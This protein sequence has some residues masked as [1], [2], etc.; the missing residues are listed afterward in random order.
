MNLAAATTR[1]PWWS[2]PYWN[3]RN[4]FGLHEGWRNWTCTHW[5]DTIRDNNPMGD[6]SC[7]FVNNPNGPMLYL[8]SWAWEESF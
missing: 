1:R 7:F 5:A 8:N 2:N 3:A 4:R 6:D